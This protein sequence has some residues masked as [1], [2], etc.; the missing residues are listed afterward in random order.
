MKI[1]IDLKEIYGETAKLNEKTRYI[2]SIIEKAGKGNEIILTGQAPVWLY[3]I[4]SHV[5][6]GKAT[7]LIYNSPVTGEVVIFDHNPF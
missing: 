7:R 4:A 1:T 3:L 2:E 5:L 6:H